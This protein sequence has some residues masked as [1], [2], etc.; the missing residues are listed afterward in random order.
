MVKFMNP[1]VV[2]FYDNGLR[3]AFQK[4][5]SLMGDLIVFL[6][7]YPIAKA[8]AHTSELGQFSGICLAG[9]LITFYLPCLSFNGCNHR[10]SLWNCRSAFHPYSFRNR[11][12]RCCSSIFHRQ[13]SRRCPCVYSRCNLREMKTAHSRRYAIVS[14]FFKFDCK[15][16]VFKFSV[17]KF[18]SS[19]TERLVKIF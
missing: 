11:N 4:F 2:F 13:V 5:L 18:M 19:V 1:I 15:I 6:R 16:P 10:I 3:R 12:R 14:L 9:T 7:G 17:K 8:I